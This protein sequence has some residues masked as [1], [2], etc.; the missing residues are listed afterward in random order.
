MKKSRLFILLDLELRRLAG[1]GIMITFI[2][3][4]LLPAILILYLAGLFWIPESH[5]MIEIVRVSNPNLN[6]YKSL[7]KDYFNTI[8]SLQDLVLGFWA[9]FPMLIVVSIISSNFISRERST[10]TF[11]LLVTRPIRRYELVASKVLAFLFLSFIVL[12][13]THTLNISAIALSFYNALG[14]S[15]VLEAIHG[16]W[17]YILYYTLGSWLY[18]F[19]I[20]GLTLIIS[21][22]T[23]KMY[24]PSMSVIGYYIA[25]EIASSTIRTIVHGYTAKTLNAF[26]RYANFSYHISVIM[27]KWLYGNLTSLTSYI[28]RPNYAL[29]LI[30]VTALP[31]FFIVISFLIIERKDLI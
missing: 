21:T 8:K 19:I 27:T 17:K 18:L 7:L 11:D 16:S 5:Q 12:L 1:S 26:L 3:F 22:Q 30:L 15:K 31:L 28:F 25:I 14:I 9:G 6:V 4:S 24:I 29:S 23:K 10:G 2:L 13:I 20:M